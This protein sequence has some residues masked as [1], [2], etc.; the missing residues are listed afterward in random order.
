MA[1]LWWESREDLAQA[2][3]T[4]EAQQAAPELLEDERRFI[5]LAR[6]A[7]WL[8]TERPIVPS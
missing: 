6:S 8:G 1:E 2:L 4:S 5:D 7:L 3:A